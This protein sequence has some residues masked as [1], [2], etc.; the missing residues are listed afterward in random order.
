MSMS[1]TADR[2]VVESFTALDLL[3]AYNRLIAPLGL[4]KLPMSSKHSA[5]I[6]R[7][8]GIPIYEG[9]TFAAGRELSFGAL[10]PY[11]A[12]KVYGTWAARTGSKE[13]TRAMVVA[14]LKALREDEKGRAAA[15]SIARMGGVPA[16]Y[17]WCLQEALRRGL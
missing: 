13:Y 10:A 1:D 2:L 14:L 11:W 9:P 16:L 7:D 15:E 3:T 6:M 5:V 17:E 4:A 12:V 8:A